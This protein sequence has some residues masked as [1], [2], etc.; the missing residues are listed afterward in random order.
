MPKAIYRCNY[1]LQRL[2][3]PCCENEEHVEREQEVIRVCGV[4]RKLC[5]LA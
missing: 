2:L 3:P 5:R 4:H 1:K